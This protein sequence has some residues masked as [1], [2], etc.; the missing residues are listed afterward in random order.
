MILIAK[1]KK[2]TNKQKLYKAV[3]NL[4]GDARVQ[5]SHPNPSLLLRVGAALCRCI[6]A[7]T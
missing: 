2:K 1:N 4:L 5:I 3:H 7:A 6:A